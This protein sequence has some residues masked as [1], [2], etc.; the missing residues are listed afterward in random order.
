ML[1]R[2]DANRNGVLDVGETW[3]FTTRVQI[4]W[5]HDGGAHAFVSRAIADRATSQPDAVTVTVS[6]PAA[7][8][9]P[10]GVPSPRKLVY[11][12]PQYPDQP[13]AAGVQAV[14]SCFVLR[15]LFFV[16]LSK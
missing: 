15:P 16:L 9:L 12:E 7:I 2:G 10:P 8:Q 6:P 4:G 14:A 13:K 5:K 11:V 1:V 3:K